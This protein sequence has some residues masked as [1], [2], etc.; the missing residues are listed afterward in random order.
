MKK[1]IYKIIAVS[2]LLATTTACEKTFDELASNPNQQDVNGFYN[3]PQNINKGVIGIY[4]YITT[5]RAMGTAG[6]LQINRGT[7]RRKFGR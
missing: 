7:R 3:T 5:P 6:R 4:A 1:N 2:L